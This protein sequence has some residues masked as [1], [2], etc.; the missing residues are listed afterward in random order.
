[1]RIADGTVC[2]G[3]M[4]KDLKLFL[5]VWGEK[6]QINMCIEEMSELTKE[7][8]KYLR[9]K[10]CEPCT[11][12][13]IQEIAD[14]KNCVEQMALMFGKEKVEA[15]QKQK[16]ER[17]LKRLKGE[18]I[19]F[20]KCS[21]KKFELEDVC[22]RPFKFTDAKDMLKNYCADEDVTKY[23][24]WSVHKNI[25][26]TENYLMSFLYKY[27]TKNFYEWAIVDKKSNKVIGAISITPKSNQSAEL[28]YVLS[29][30]YWGRGILPR[31]AKIVIDY[32]FKLGYEKVFAK[33]Q[34]ENLKSERVMQKLGMQFEGVSRKADFK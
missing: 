31:S 2:R 10:N 23:L 27:N 21:T 9:Y 19:D 17:T 6:A 20:E 33:C 8:C 1:M 32:I 18:G 13:I 12:D 34:V 3:L 26:D 30:N 22:L 28:G 4:E 5:D 14:V 25:N 7:L 11:D 29:K 15:V 16:I 24:P